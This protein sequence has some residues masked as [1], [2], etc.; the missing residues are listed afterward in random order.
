VRGRLALRAP[1]LLRVAAGAARWALMPL[2]FLHALLAHSP[3]AT[4]TSAE[5]A[6]AMAEAFAAAAAGAALADIGDED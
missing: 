2:C 5:E 1:D 6:G 4:A 3:A